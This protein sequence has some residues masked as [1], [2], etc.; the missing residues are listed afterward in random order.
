M[1]KLHL[2][3]FQLSCLVVETCHSSVVFR[4]LGF[5][6]GSWSFTHSCESSR[7]GLIFSIVLGGVSLGLIRIVCFLLLYKYNR[8]RYARLSRAPP[9]N[10]CLLLYFEFTLSLVNRIMRILHPSGHTAH[11]PSS[12][13]DSDSDI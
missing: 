5:W 2:S 4:I 13:T 11:T 12:F 8:M 6:P 9:D 3:F 1:C 7:S 10:H